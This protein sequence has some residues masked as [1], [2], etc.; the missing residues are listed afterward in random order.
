[1]ETAARER[2]RRASQ[3]AVGDLAQAYLARLHSQAE[4]WRMN[5]TARQLIDEAVAVNHARVKER[6]TRREYGSDLD[7]FALYL[8]SVSQRSFYTAERKHVLLFLDHL[9]AQGGANPDRSRLCCRWCKER[10]YPDG[11]HGSGYSPSTRKGYLSAIRFLYRHFLYEVTLPDHDPSA[12]VQG[13]QVVVTAQYTPNREEVLSLFDAPGQP[14]DRL[15]AH[16][17]FYAPSRRAPFATARWSDIDLEEGTWRIVG[18]GKKVDVFD[19]HPRL[20]RMFR[21]YLQWQLSE[22]ERHPA[23]REALSDPDTAFVLLTRNGKPLG[24][25]SIAKML[26]WRAIRAGV[27]VIPAKGKWDAPGGKTSRVCPHSLRR[28][29]AQFA[30]NDPDHP[31]PIDVVSAVLRHSDISTTRRH[32]A[33]TK[34]DRARKA[35]VTV[36]V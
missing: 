23:I 34:P 24:G 31:Q 35:L 12:G 25:D 27:G 11:K 16:W 15:L 18:K 3:G 22:A 9:E 10:G 14:R 2:P 7:H 28:A 21:E 30:L 17:L 1:M 26:K 4:A 36:N 32:Y 13:P 33:P 19:L 29:W 8:E 5:L 6:A 20:L